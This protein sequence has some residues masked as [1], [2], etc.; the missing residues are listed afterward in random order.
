[1]N[2]DSLYIAGADYNY[3]IS[4]FHTLHICLSLKR[5]I[6]LE[7]WTNGL[8][9][10]LEKMFGVRLVSN[11]M[12]FL[13][14][15]A[16]LNAMNKEV[17]GARILEEARKCKLVPKE[18]FREQNMADDGG[19]AK[20]L[21][22]DNVHQLR[23]PAAIALVNASDCY[24]CIPHAMA[25]HIFQSFGVEDAAVMAMLETIQEIF[26]PQDSIWGLQGICRLNH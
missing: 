6:A 26:F 13:L 21:F 18:I 22:Y 14:M 5:G 24:D 10:M 9:V 15:E 11:S 8:S 16:E 4:Q 19:L 7:C 1:M 20:T 2:E 23:V 17:Y 25:L 12:Q 3:N